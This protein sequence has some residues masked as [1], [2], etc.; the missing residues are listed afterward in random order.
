[1][2][3]DDLK[4]KLFVGKSYQSLKDQI[5]KLPNGVSI[6][7]RGVCIKVESKEPKI[8]MFRYDKV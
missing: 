6:P 2:K 5:K 8:E 3:D 1:M 7:N 4:Q